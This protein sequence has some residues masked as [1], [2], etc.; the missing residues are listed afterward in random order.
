[1]R[2]GIN[3]SKGN[4]RNTK[5][6]ILSLGKPFSMSFNTVTLSEAA[7]EIRRVRRTT[8]RVCICSTRVKESK[9][10]KESGGGGGIKL[11]GY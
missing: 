7:N 5:N 11:K 8:R 10:Q 1:M 9:N 4:E 2:I 6:A 3:T